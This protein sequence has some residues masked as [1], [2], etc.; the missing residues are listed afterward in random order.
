MVVFVLHHAGVKA[1]D[2]ARRHRPV[3][4][5]AAVADAPGARHRGAQPGDRQAA[6]PA[7]HPLIAQQLDA[8]G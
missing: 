7:Q 4:V 5:H 2:L 3:A 8:R 1:V 6:L